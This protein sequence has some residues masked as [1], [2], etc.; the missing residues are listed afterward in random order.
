MFLGGTVRSVED[1]ALLR[2]MGLDF[3]EISI[4]DVRRFHEFL[5]DYKR[6]IRGSDFFFLCHGPQEGD[7]NDIQSLEDVY[8]PKLM[9]TIPL[10]QKLGST[11]LTIHLW[12]DP[13]FVMER[14]ITYK[15]GFLKRVLETA[16]SYSVNINIENLSESPQDL[17]PVFEALPDLGLTLDVG[18]GQLLAEEN[19]S[20]EFVERLPERI[21]HVH[22]HDN[23]GGS[24]PHD[25]LHLPVGDGI[26]NFAAI[27]RALSVLGYDRTM[28]IELK[29]REI[30]QCINR[31]KD[32]LKNSARA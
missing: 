16:I 21:R 20:F 29:P 8:F 26:V 28:T 31:V 6:E 13:R 19:K 5:P 10:V 7:P 25:D 32:L 14:V 4:P 11:L 30:E 24:S 3:G 18:H 1:V 17:L 27:F 2:A 23:F 15:V 9:D 12:M 22:I